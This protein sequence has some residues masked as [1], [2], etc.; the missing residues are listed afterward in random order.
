MRDRCRCRLVIQTSVP[1]TVITSME[2][3]QRLP[4]QI[5]R[6]V[7]QRQLPWRLTLCRRRRGRHRRLRCRRY[8][9]RQCPRHR[10]HHSIR[11]GK[12]QVVQQKTQSNLHVSQAL[13]VWSIRRQWQRIQQQSPPSSHRVW[14]RVRMM[15]SYQQHI[16]NTST[17]HERER[18][19]ER[20]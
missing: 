17:I 5:N 13:I 20:S 11:H 12:V 4:L 15:S 2:I 10:P 18:F 14:H 16:R 19:H 6:I 7:C 1:T 3:V 9:H 8:H